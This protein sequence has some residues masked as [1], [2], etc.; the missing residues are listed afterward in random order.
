[1]I[2]YALPN[3]LAKKVLGR[4][5]GWRDMGVPPPP[6]G[7]NT[8]ALQFSVCLDLAQKKSLIFM[9]YVVSHLI[10]LKPL[11]KIGTTFLS[12]K[13]VNFKKFEIRGI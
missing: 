2:T 1:M 13:K 12:S 9:G 10:S 5:C 8:F 4:Q 6:N 7:K 11:H 3:I